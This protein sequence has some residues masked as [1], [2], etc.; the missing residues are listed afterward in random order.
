MENIPG[1]AEV[2][3]RVFTGQGIW[4]ISERKVLSYILNGVVVKSIYFS[5]KSLNCRLKIVFFVFT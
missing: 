1:P 2:K 3:Y 5:Q 4:E